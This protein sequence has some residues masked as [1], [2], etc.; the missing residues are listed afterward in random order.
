MEKLRSGSELCHNLVFLGKHGT[1]TTSSGLKLVT[2][3]GTFD[4]QHFASSTVHSEDLTLPYI[5]PTPFSKLV[6][7]ASECDILITASFP[8]SIG[9][10]SSKLP[11]N[12]P[13][14]SQPISELL[15]KCKPKYHFVG[16]E[17][18]FWER[19]PFAWE[20]GEKTRVTRFFSIGDANNTDK[21]RWFY[22]FQISPTTL[23]SP[24]IIVPPN[25]SA[26]P[27]SSSR[28]VKRKLEDSVSQPNYIFD[29][30]EGKRQKRSEPPAHYV[31]RNCKIP[32]HW[33]E[34]CPQR[35]ERAERDPNHPPDSYVC[36]VCNIKGHYIR[37]CPVKKDQDRTGNKG[38]MRN[39]PR[40]REEIGPDSC[41][42][43]L[44]NPNL[45][46]HI[47]TSIG[48][49]C[50]LTLA[51]G[52]II[53]TNGSIIPGGGHI[54]IIPIGHYQTAKAL[55]DDIRESTL[56][57]MEVYK[58][59]L[60]KFYAKYDHDLVIWDVS[61]STGRASHFFVSVCPVPKSLSPQ[62]EETFKTAAG[63]AG[64]SFEPQEELS[65]PRVR[66][67]SDFFKVDLPNGKSLVY[68]IPP[69]TAGGQLFNLQFGRLVLAKLL[70]DEGRADWRACQL[71]E[72]EETRDA[73]EFKQAFKEFDPS[74]QD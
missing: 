48:N 65:T 18:I 60:K 24:P 39:A 29:S 16:G 68:L 9:A 61:R 50:Y 6:S 72:E 37:D 56:Q 47:I 22:A 2:C 34:D 33:I 41:W 59:A 69:Y 36:K 74:L 55:P 5:E 54:L 30:A 71:T 19:E 42:F 27:F 4:L 28:G 52:Q 45:N 43:C 25:T 35:R 46:K 13:Q 63:E 64:F 21:Q 67:A 66:D 58:V 15:S 57:E 38:G 20:D 44:S 3:G 51:K 73:M 11:P 40:A 12:I 32:G 49:E 70:G 10:H 26:N 7:S 8:A 53:D 31:C 23:T 14:G 17:G 62:I 1:F